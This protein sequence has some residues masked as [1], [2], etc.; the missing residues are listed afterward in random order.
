MNRFTIAALLTLAFAHPCAQAEES[1]DLSFNIA[2]VSDYRYRGISQ[3]RLQPA[4]QGGLDYVHR[5]SGLYAG[6]WASTITWTGDAGGGGHV[7]LDLYAGIKGQLA[8]GFAY[9]A[10][11]LH[12]AYPANGLAQAPGFANAN[13]NELY[14]QLAYGWGQ[15]KYSWSASNLFGFTDSKHSGYADLALNPKLNE[16]LTLNLHAGHQRVAAH[17]DASYSDWKV[18]LTRDF[19]QSSAA[20]AVVGSN[21]NKL[22]YTSPENGKYL[23]KTALVLALSKTF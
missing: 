9:D 1:A 10:G 23:G 17:A 5:P 7:E 22:A 6:A 16:T 15:A 3:T 20:L 12:Y 18:G 11:V 4:L 21:A 19:A 8:P 2:G 14:G 13:T